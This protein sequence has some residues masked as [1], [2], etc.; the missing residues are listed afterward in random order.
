MSRRLPAEARARFQFIGVCALC[1]LRS[2]C[3]DSIVQDWRSISN[4]GSLASVAKGS[5]SG[6][7]STCLDSEAA[8]VYRFV[9]LSPK[10][11]THVGVDTFRCDRSV[12]LTRCSLEAL[13]SIKHAGP[14]TS[15]WQKGGHVPGL[16]HHIVHGVLPTVSCLVSFSSFLD[17]RVF[18]GNSF[19]AV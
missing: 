1:R 8:G 6:C 15:C 3:E 13:G 12:A 2:W 10:H 16:V 7:W 14:T 11:R 18:A 4:K 17:T 9:R 5:E 19:R